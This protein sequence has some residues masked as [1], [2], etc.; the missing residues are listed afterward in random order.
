[1]RA[2]PATTWL[3]LMPSPRRGEV[4]TV[5]TAIAIRLLFGSVRPRPGSRAC[6]ARPQGDLDGARAE[7]AE[8]RRLKPE[9][10]SL[11][12]WREYQPWIAI[13]QYRA[14]R[15][16]TLYVGLHEAGFPDE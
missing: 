7:L 14:L 12:R 13:P 15:E 8:A 6:P 2:L 3:F 1:M 5:S 10:D 11:A 9:I 16:K 4:G